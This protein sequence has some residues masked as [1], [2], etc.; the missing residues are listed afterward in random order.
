MLNNNTIKHPSITFCIREF[1]ALLQLLDTI[2]SDFFIFLESGNP[3]ILRNCPI[4]NDQSN[5][6]NNHK[7]PFICEIVV[8]TLED[9]ETNTQNDTTNISKDE[10]NE[11]YDDMMDMEP[12]NDDNKEEFVVQTPTSAN[13]PKYNNVNKEAMEPKIIANEHQII[14][15]SPPISQLPQPQLQDN[16][17]DDDDDDSELKLD[18]DLTDS[19]D[20][21]KPLITSNI[22][23][24]MDQSTAS[25]FSFASPSNNNNNSNKRKVIPSQQSISSQ[26]SSLNMSYID[27]TQSDI[28]ITQSDNS[29]EHFNIKKIKEN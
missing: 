29:D 8:A 22:T 13:K 24:I 3:I 21:K 7:L 4:N 23:N 6:N 9:E 15:P 18:L 10:M 28:E 11:M 1:K 17:N 19:Y 14:Q 26:Q 5:T 2:Q 27:E 25:P 20:S 16:D 12:Y